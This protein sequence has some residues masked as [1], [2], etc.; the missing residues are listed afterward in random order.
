MRSEPTAVEWNALYKAAAEFRE[1]EPWAWV[2]EDDI[3]DV[4]NPVTGEIG[5]CCVMGELGHGSDVAHKGPFDSGTKTGRNEP[6]PCG[7]G[8]KYKK[9][10]GMSH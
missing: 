4:Q 7:S 3:F 6:C 5:Y 2:T 9:C 1:I 10:C 8:K